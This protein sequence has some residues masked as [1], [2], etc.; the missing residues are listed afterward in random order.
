MAGHQMGALEKNPKD[1]FL[2]S[3]G[4]VSEQYLQVHTKVY[5]SIFEMVQG[6]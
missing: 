4:E 2:A 6:A 1:I 5:T 3:S